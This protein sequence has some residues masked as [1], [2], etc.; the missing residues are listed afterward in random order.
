MISLSDFATISEC[1]IPGAA[2]STLQDFRLPDSSG[3]YAYRESNSWLSPTSNRFIVWYVFFSLSELNPFNRRHN[4]KS[5]RDTLE[6]SEMSLDMDLQDNHLKL[7][8]QNTPILD[9]LSINERNDQ[10]I[11]L[12]ATVGSVHKLVLPHPKKLHH[13]I[14]TPGSERLVRT[15]IFHN[16][17]A[18]TVK[19]PLNF[20]VLDNSYPV[21][22]S[23][24]GLA[25]VNFPVT[26]C[27][28]LSN[29]GEPFFVL[30][31]NS[32]S[33]VMVKMAQ[34]PEEKTLV[35]ELRTNSLMDKLRGFVP[36][37]IRSSQDEESA[38]SIVSHN[39]GNETLFFA[40]C[41]DM[42]IRIWSAVRR[43]CIASLNLLPSHESPSESHQNALSSAH[44]PQI[45]KSVSG[46][47]FLAVYLPSPEQ[48]QFL[49]FK[50]LQEA[51]TLDLERVASLN[52]PLEQDLVDFEVVGSNILTLWQDSETHTRLR[53]ASFSL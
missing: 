35:W 32:G 29:A 7:R 15:S 16:F 5:S 19:N 1:L 49:I 37:I 30:A 26:S 52:A 31:N 40:F 45:R 2:Q 18:E 6:L 42:K 17:S 20:Y 12:L 44:R 46:G 28:W 23:S 53:R 48:K 51:P 4:R 36:S 43:K 41:R 24:L 22:G 11:I 50:L 3:G 21:G 27:C 8:L 47:F 14:P 39:F 34:K 9:G 38:I 10:V 13:N 25:G 33:L